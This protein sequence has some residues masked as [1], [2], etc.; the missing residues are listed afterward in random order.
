MPILNQ[1][2]L[3]KFPEIQQRFGCWTHGR[4]QQKA[5]AFFSLSAECRE[6]FWCRSA[7]HLF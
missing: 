2:E 6:S 3:E 4:S 5:D 1:K 7:G